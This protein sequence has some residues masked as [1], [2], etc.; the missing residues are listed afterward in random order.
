[1][2]IS[3]WSSDVCSSDLVDRQDAVV[4]RLAGHG[5]FP[6]GANPGVHGRHRVV[7]ERA[8]G[9]GDQVAVRVK[10]LFEGRD[11]AVVEAVEI[12]LHRFR[13]LG[14]GGRHGGFLRGLRGPA[15]EVWTP[16][17]RRCNA[18]RGAPT[19]EGVAAVCRFSASLFSARIGGG[20]KGRYCRGWGEFL[21]SATLTALYA[22]LATFNRNSGVSG[23]RG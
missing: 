7:G 18:G 5:R 8:A 6:P 15:A 2:R 1:M 17:R 3:D 13:E 12:Q 11:V 14:I 19:A 16:A 23:T 4:A 10:H 20:R 22:R 9:A 21:V